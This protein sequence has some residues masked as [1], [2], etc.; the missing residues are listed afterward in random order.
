MFE[1]FR[2]NFEIE[3]ENII[4][5]DIR[6]FYINKY[7]IKKALEYL[8]TSACNLF[9]RLDCLLAKDNGEFYT[10]T[11]ILNSDK[12]NTKCALSC[13][14]SYEDAQIADVSDIFK[15]ADP[16]EREIFDLFGIK[17]IN[18]PNLK[19]ILLPD[20]FKGHPLRKDYKMQDERL[21]WN[22]E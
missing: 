18:H 9:E 22:Y 11:Y 15:S 17:F 3:K 16:D 7:D 8:K 12:Y 21:M 2:K 5:P 1:D 14:I 4:L 19:R 20:D 13:N 10:V 6:E